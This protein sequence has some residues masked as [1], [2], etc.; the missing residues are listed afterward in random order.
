MTIHI[1]ASSKDIADTVLLPGDPLRARAIANEY[2]TEVQCYNQVR[3][4]LGFTGWYKGKRVSIQG[5]GM[6][7][8]SLLI[9]TNELIDLGA[10]RLLRVGTCG[11]YQA[12]LHI[13]DIILAMSASTDN[14]INKQ[15]F[16]HMDYAPGASF[17]LLYRA[18]QNALEK[19]MKVHVGN[20]L[21]SDLFYQQDARW[22]LWAEY[23]VLGVEMESSALY[24]LAAKKNIEAL[25]ILTVSDSL[26][27]GE[28]AHADDRQSH[29]HDMADLA[30]SL[31]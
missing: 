17:P 14:S 12:H 9:Y 26:I 8:P 25:S 21:S 2:L 19:K 20:I 7:I 11:A 30:L 18:Y 10:R 24:T 6:G 22:K 15:I 3:N 29:F 31:C 5:T 16:D 1:S 4:M 28:Q 13:G 27:N 23:Q